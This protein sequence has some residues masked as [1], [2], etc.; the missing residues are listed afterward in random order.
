M[1]PIWTSLEFCRFL[2][3]SMQNQLFKN[4]EAMTTYN[5]VYLLPSHAQAH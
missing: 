1:V 2:K 4:T 5:M 3:G